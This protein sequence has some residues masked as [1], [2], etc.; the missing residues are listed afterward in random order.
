MLA[1]AVMAEKRA[2]IWHGGGAVF[3]AL[4]ERERERGSEGRRR[5]KGFN[6]LKIFQ[7]LCF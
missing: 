2:Q 1:L 5:E 6:G 4:S 3:V 7:K